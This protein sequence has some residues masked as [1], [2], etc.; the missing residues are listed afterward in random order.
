MITR[1]KAKAMECNESD[2][3]SVCSARSS[4]TFKA[5]KLAA[6]AAHLRRIATI[7]RSQA[8]L[9]EAV[10]EAEL[11]AQIAAFEAQETASQASNCSCRSGRRS[12]RSNPTGVKSWLDTNVPVTS[13]DCDTQVPLPL[14]TGTQEYCSTPVRS[15]HL[16]PTSLSATVPPIISAQ[17]SFQPPLMTA[18]TASVRQPY[19]NQAHASQGCIGTDILPR[20]QAYASQGGVV[21]ALPPQP[22]VHASQVGGSAVPLPQ[23]SITTMPA[24]S[25]WQPTCSHT[26]TT[27]GTQ[28]EI[29]NKNILLEN[30][31]TL[32]SLAEAITSL[33]VAA[34]KPKVSFPLPIFNGQPTDWLIF[35]KIYDESSSSFTPTENLIRISAALRGP[36]RDSVAVLLVAARDPSEVIRALETAFARPEQII[37]VEIAAVRALPKLSN[38]ESAN[39]INVFACKV[40]NCVEVVRLLQRPEYLASPELSNEIVSKLT[41]LL[42]SRWADFAASREAAGPGRYRLELLADF[43]TH[44]ANLRIRYQVF[45]PEVRA[46]STGEEYCHLSVTSPAQHHSSPPMPNK[47][48]CSF[49]KTT[50]HI[51][52]A[53]NKFSRLS[54]QNRWKWATAQRVCHKCLRRAHTYRTCR[55]FSCEVDGCK[56]K[57]SH[58]TLLHRS[59]SIVAAQPSVDAQTH[60]VVH[61][62]LVDISSHAGPSSN[63]AVS[64]PP[65][66]T[67]IRESCNCV[68]VND[69][70]LQEYLRVGSRDISKKIFS[71]KRPNCQP[72][73]GEHHSSGSAPRFR[74]RKRARL[75][76][77]WRKR[78]AQP[79]CALRL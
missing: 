34:K 24:A 56:S 1:S 73:P 71:A 36:A 41:P 67:K 50:G 22:L 35:K 76:V 23:P 25:I 70:Q 14:C 52:T 16:I 13:G 20:P 39:E 5:Q 18:P 75:R 4:A 66:F 42:R 69:A 48:E 26:H 47:G 68:V 61:E 38:H 7:K 59:S 58:H 57:S 17:D 19:N 27:L 6:E 29:Y 31:N 45:T 60:T 30:Q 78:E 2:V 53:C 8:A 49:C 54:S 10:A 43:L 62:P 37:L 40:R 9:E 64:E 32:Q 77:R 51:V 79:N 46:R 63:A 11:A 65:I 74:G 12:R 28:N 3:S 55:R 72:S 15:G 33:A 44:E 21:T